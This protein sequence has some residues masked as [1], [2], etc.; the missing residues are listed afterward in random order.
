MER[1]LAP[2]IG[3][4]VSDGLKEDQLQRI[5]GVERRRGAVALLQAVHQNAQCEHQG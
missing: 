2:G 3:R 4:Q 1:S 5:G